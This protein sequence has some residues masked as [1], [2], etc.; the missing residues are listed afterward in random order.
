MKTIRLFI[1]LIIL[2]I[3]TTV[4]A[5]VSSPDTN[6]WKVETRLPSYVWKLSGTYINDI[7]YRKWGLL[8]IDRYRN[9]YI[10]IPDTWLVAPINNIPER[11]ND[12]KTLANH[13]PI[14]INKYLQN[15]VLSYPKTSDNS[16][17]EE[18]NI[19]IFWHSSYWEKDAGRYKTHFQT[20]INLTS[21]TEIWIFKLQKN[22]SF[23]RF[24]YQIEK[25][26][27][28]LPT[29]IEVLDHSVKKE[30]TLFTCTPIGWLTGRWIIKSTYIEEIPQ[31]RAKYKKQIQRFINKLNKL[32]TE[33]KEAS[34]K[35]IVKKLTYLK[36]K[37]ENKKIMI[38]IDYI[39]AEI[40]K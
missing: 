17:G 39:L 8:E 40:L 14:N 18:W 4:F 1:L 15:W 13:D 22:W 28:T 30:L 3:H 32:D 29:D 21:N 36:K 35:K 2:W 27:N 10:V 19:V 24:R 37:T 33:K 34:I 5:W 20:I 16:Y 6:I 7:E 9:E 12:F 38:L 11:L 25:S 23:K 26:Y 31:I